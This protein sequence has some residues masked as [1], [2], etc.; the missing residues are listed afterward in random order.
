MNNCYFSIDL[1]KIFWC[2]SNMCGFNNSKFQKLSWFN[3]GFIFTNSVFIVA[4]FCFNAV[5]TRATPRYRCYYFLCIFII[6]FFV[7]LAVLYEDAVILGAE[8]ETVLLAADS[9]RKKPFCVVSRTVCNSNSFFNDFRC[10]KIN[11]SKLGKM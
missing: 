4:Y 3:F 9:Y 10:C 1:Y 11:D 8:N 2:V 7:I 5:K 6:L